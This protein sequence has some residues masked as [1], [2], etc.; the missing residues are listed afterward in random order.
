MQLTVENVQEFTLLVARHPEWQAEL[1][2]LVLTDE[3]LELPNIVRRLAEART[4]PRNDS[5]TRRSGVVTSKARL[6]GVEKRLGRASKRA[7]KASKSGLTAS[8][9]GLTA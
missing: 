4:T 9:S 2:R 1:R 5:V 7:W 6:E 8:K 3:L